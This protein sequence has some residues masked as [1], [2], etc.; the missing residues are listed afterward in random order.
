MESLH[1]GRVPDDISNIPYTKIVE[2][3]VKMHWLLVTTYA[4]SLRNF[5]QTITQPLVY[6]GG[7]D[8][9]VYQDLAFL[10]TQKVAKIKHYFSRCKMPQIQVKSSEGKKKGVCMLMHIFAQTVVYANGTTY[11]HNVLHISTHG[12]S[13]NYF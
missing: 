10:V 5:L 7:T 11:I 3:R 6:T 8:K 2:I 13:H 12:Y 4:Q 9:A 1:K